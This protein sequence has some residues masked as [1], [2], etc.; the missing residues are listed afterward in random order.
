MLPGYAPGFAVLRIIN[1]VKPQHRDT[2]RVPEPL[3]REAVPVGGL[4]GHSFGAEGELAVVVFHDHPLAV[5]DV[6]A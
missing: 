5:A 6:A 1:T 2:V 4:G 3:W